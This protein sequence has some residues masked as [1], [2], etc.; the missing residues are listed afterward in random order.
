MGAASFSAYS[1]RTG[2]ILHRRPR[3]SGRMMCRMLLISDD[4]LA[5]ACRPM[6]HQEGERARKLEDPTMRG[7]VDEAALAQKLQARRAARK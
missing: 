1:N 3:S 5:T 4:E 7:P 6:A 2:G